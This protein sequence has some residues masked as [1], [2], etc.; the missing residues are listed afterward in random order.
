MKPLKKYTEF[1][2]KQ[3]DNFKID[4]NTELYLEGEISLKKWEY[5]FNKINENWF[6]NNVENILQNKIFPVLKS[7]KEKIKTAG[8]KGI[9]ILKKIFKYVTSFASKNPILS[10]I[11]VTI[12]ILFV[13]GI[14]TASAA[15]GTDPNTLVPNTEVL[16]AAIGFVQD[17][18]EDGSITTLMDKMQVQ[19]Y[20]VDLRNDGVIDEN[21]SENI[22]KMGDIATKLMEKAA[23]EEEYQP[24]FT[25]LVNFGAE[26]KNYIFTEIKSVGYSSTNLIL[27]K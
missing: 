22:Q 20:L 25:K 15:T 13:I 5:N 17:L 19:A 7:L 12:I 23:K 4:K 26:I 9:M 10:K 3:I 16:N 6:S 2:N 21:W 1:I 24:I 8:Q 27:T 18:Y 14:V 11:L